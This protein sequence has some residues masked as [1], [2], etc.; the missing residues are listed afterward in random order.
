MCVQGIH[1]VLAGAVEHWIHDHHRC[2][3]WSV[4]AVSVVVVVVVSLRQS[5]VGFAK[6]SLLSKERNK[7]FDFFIVVLRI[8]DKVENIFFLESEIFAKS[9]VLY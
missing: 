2:I 5:T 7:V 6:I 1:Q 9:T 4:S 3:G 8:R